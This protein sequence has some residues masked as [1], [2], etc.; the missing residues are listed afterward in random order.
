MKHSYQ[1]KHELT[2]ASER[3]LAAAAAWAGGGHD[4]LD[5]PELLVGLLAEPECRAAIMLA[6]HG[7]DLAA[8]RRR[9]PELTPLEAVE[10]RHAT[11]FSPALETAIREAALR[12][13]D[14]PAPQA[15]ATEHLLLGLLATPHESSQ[16][17]ANQGVE[18]AAV[19]AEVR[20]V[21][22]VQSTP[23]EVEPEVAEAGGSERTTKVAPAAA[24]EGERAVAE[25]DEAALATSRDDVALVRLLDAAANRA[26]EALRVID[27]YVRFVLDDAHLTTLA[28][29][30]RHELTAALKRL[31]AELRLVCRDTPHD[32]GTTL[33]TAAERRRRDTADVLAANFNRFQQALRSLEEYGKVL[34]PSFATAIEAL[35]YKSYTIQ[36]A[37]GTTE[38]GRGRLSELR[39]YVLIDGRESP[40]AFEQFVGALIDAGADALQLRDKGLSDR[41]LL[42]RARLLRRLTEDRPTLCIINDRPDLAALA[43]ADGVHVGQEELSVRDARAIVGPGVLIGVSTHSIEQARQAVID[44][45]DYIGVGPTFP[46]TTKHFA[47]H[48]GLELLRQVAAEI[49]L[50]ALAIGGVDRQNV[51]DVLAT[52]FARIAVSGAVLNAPDPAAAVRELR[53]LL[54]REVSGRGPGTGSFFGR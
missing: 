11:R 12:V 22:G 17:L 44:G 51:A 40:E 18:L 6:R 41:D 1:Q 43:R 19:E 23:V 49:R 52:G 45:A 29:E 46:S 20:R 48:T 16:W 26:S 42:E 25:N 33:S 13:R 5:L 34:D 10:T 39:L 30:L 2:P 37:I 7:I 4:A 21:Y 35:R 3:A 53:E 54:N 32:V 50:P 24:V 8:V 15:L 36:R 28:K 27:D 47:E 38:R 31:P 9:W 14:F